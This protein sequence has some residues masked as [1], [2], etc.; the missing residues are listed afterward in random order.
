VD[1]ANLPF[2]LHTSFM[3]GTKGSH[4]VLESAELRRALGDR[5]VYYENADG[6]TCLIYGFM[7]KVIIG[8]TD[9]RVDDPDHAT[10]D[11]AEVE[12]MLGALKE[13]FPD[14][15]IARE[16]IV[17]KFCG[18][19]PLPRAS[20]GFTGK[21][22]RDH[23]IEVLDRG[24]GRPFPVICLVGGKWTT[25]RALAEQSAD[26]VLRRL[27]VPRRSSTEETPIGGGRGYPAGPGEKAR[28]IERV[29]R[30][31]GLSPERVAALL[32][33]YGTAAEEHASLAR[34]RPGAESPLASLPE[35]TAG[36][37]ERIAAG[38]FVEHLSDIVCRRSVIALLG[39]AKR[40]ALEELARVAGGVLGWDEA[41]RG[42]EIQ[43][44]L[45]EVERG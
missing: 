44:A 36:E 3:G 33:R 40:E 19:R 7:D 38:D 30:E 29:A 43:R 21:I 18:V 42:D 16:E 6:R 39:R 24:A 23:R 15:R 11:E 37:I 32:D 1:I 20:E 25:F 31:S 27:E 9:I 5:M 14:L 2:G 41:R 4:L 45:A 8:S 35:Y 22:P 17:F 10:C 34:S 26:E 13:V 28:W 12:Y